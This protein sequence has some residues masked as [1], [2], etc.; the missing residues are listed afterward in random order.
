MLS[1]VKANVPKESKKKIVSGGGTPKNAEKLTTDAALIAATELVKKEHEKD[2]KYVLELL[3]NYENLCT[4]HNK[5]NIIEILNKLLE[6]F[7]RSGVDTAKITAKI[8]EII[9]KCSQNELDTRKID[10]NAK[11]EPYR[12]N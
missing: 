11:S 9:N 8:T 4:Y 3:K 10:N 2:V 12:F 7:A 1:N 5:Q 6:I